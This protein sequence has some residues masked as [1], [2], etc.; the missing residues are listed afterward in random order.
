MKTLLINAH[1]NPTA[2]SYSQDLQ[3]HF[4]QQWQALNTNETLTV[5]NLYQQEIPQLNEHV[6]TLFAKQAQQQPLTET[7]QA[8]ATRMAEI[9]AQFKAH[10]RIVI[11]MPLHNF[12][13]P[14]K[15]KDYMDN[16]LIAR[17]TF[18]YT[19]GGS[20]GLMTDNRKVL[21]LQSS[22]SIYTNNDRYTSLEFSQQY[23]REMFTNIMGFE[24][25]DVVRAQ[26]TALSALNRETIL[27]TAFAEMD[28]ILPEFVK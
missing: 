20:E 18:R 21:L 2:P 27:A 10:K 5:I 28:S 26:G 4:V 3:N 17:E 25:F 14:S 7:E 12:N 9:L 19:S 24:C 1:P 15:L 13:I 23:L 8:T 11:V 16:I 6:L 22:G